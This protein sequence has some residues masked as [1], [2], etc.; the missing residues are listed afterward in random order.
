MEKKTVKGYSSIEEMCKFYGIDRSTYDR[1]R[2]SGLTNKK[3][4]TGKRSK[5]NKMECKDHLG[6][7]HKSISEMCKFYGIS[8]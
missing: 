3:A 2:R 4:L 1:P 5:T 8:R 6:N 7:V